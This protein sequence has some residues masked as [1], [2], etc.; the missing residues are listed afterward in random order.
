MCL[1]AGQAP[2][3]ERRRQNSQAPIA[4]PP[5]AVACSQRA[6]NQRCARPGRFARMVQCAAEYAA[7][8]V[9]CSRLTGP[10][11][12]IVRLR[13]RHAGR[14]RAHGGGCCAERKW[15]SG[16]RPPAGSPATATTARPKA[17]NRGRS[18]AGSGAVIRAAYRIQ[19]RVYRPRQARTAASRFAGT[20]RAARPK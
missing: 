11:G 19:A 13:L 20:L 10:Y 12:P 3:C 4:A 7:P 9:D 18:A 2:A 14:P 17:C 8:Q 1:L 16:R 5:A 15:A 6:S